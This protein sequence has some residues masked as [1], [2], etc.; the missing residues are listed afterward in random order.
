VNHVHVGSK[1]FLEEPIFAIPMNATMHHS[2]F[3]FKNNIFKRNCAKVRTRHG[4]TPD[5]PDILKQKRG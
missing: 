1:I 4:C 5:A 3:S 2:I